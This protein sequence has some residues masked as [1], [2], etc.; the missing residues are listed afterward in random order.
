MHRLPV[1]A[2]YDLVGF[3]HAPRINFGEAAQSGE[4]TVE[5]RFR[6]KA[7]RHHARRA[8]PTVVLPLWLLVFKP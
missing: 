1:A 2:T 5:D 4:S 7:D 8:L 6:F 3:G